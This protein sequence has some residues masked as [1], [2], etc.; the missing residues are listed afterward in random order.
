MIIQVQ[1]PYLNI[2]PSSLIQHVPPQ[3]TPLVDPRM[4]ELPDKPHPD[5]LHHP[6]RPHIRHRRE[7]INP[8]QPQFLKPMTQT[9]PRRL[10]RIPKPPRL[11]PQPPS[12]L[13]AGGTTLPPSRSAER[14]P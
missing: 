1:N 6:H 11:A 9:F 2:P 5:L 7:R 10:R 3:P 12:D 4:V 8:L 13:H 14:T